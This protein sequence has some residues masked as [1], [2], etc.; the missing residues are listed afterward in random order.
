MHFWQM[1]NAVYDVSVNLTES[2][3]RS[4]NFYN[5]I[6]E[7]Q[8]FDVVIFEVF[9]CDAMVGLGHYFDAPIIGF[10][11]LGP[12]KWTSDLVGLADMPSHIPYISNGFSDRMTFL[13]RV[14]NSLSYWYEDLAQPWKYFPR[15]QKLLEQIFPN[16]KEMPSIQELKKSV[17]LVFVNSH[18]SYGI[19]QPFAPNLIEI[20]G[21][22]IKRTVEPL[23]ADVQAFLDDA[24]NGAVYFSLGSNV[25][26]SKLPAKQ[27]Q[28]I[29]N[30]FEEF[31]NIRILIKNEDDFV[32]PSHNVSDV[33]V[34]RWFNQEAILSHRNLKVF[35]THGGAWL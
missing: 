6:R 33:L 21:V 35:I 27:K 18:V 4:Q 10:S 3:L 20:G 26:L 16:G 5:F 7:R 17:S 2:I 28:I 8:H 1:A 12:T 34:R 22:H 24:I 23:T 32:I 31:P 19:P 25:Q 13:Q 15:Q 29:A 14:Y 30:A 9:M 11:T